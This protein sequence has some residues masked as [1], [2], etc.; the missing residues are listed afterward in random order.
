MAITRAVANA[1]ATSAQFN[2][3][4]DHLEGASGSTLAYFLRVLGSNNFTIRLPDAGGTQE[5]R[6]QDSGGTSVCTIDSDGNVT[7]A[8]TQATTGNTTLTANLT[9]GGTAAVT[10]NTSVAANL[11]VGGT[12]EL[13]SS[14]ITT[15]TA[16]G[17]LKH[18]AGGLEFDASAITTGGMLKGDS[19]GVMEIL[20]K[21]AANSLLTMNAGATDFA[22]A[23]TSVA[24]S[25]I[26]EDFKDNRALLCWSDFT[27]E[28]PAN[29]E[30]FD[31][32]V[33]FHY[34]GGEI[35]A[36]ASSNSGGQYQITTTATGNYWSSFDT[37]YNVVDYTKDPYF[38]ARLT[39]RAANSALQVQAWGFNANG[40]AVSWDDTTNDCAMFR[41][42]TTGNLFAVTGNG[43]AETT[44]D[45]GSVHTLGNQAVFEIVS[46][47]NGG[48]YVFK[49]NGTTRAT[50]TGTLPDASMRPILGIANNTTT[51]LILS[52]IDYMV[53]TQDRT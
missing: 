35:A 21:G 34:G 38:A 11:D 31:Y 47:S 7:F 30:S 1:T 32:G 50:H 15:S 13:G 3:I 52:G 19:S 41:S 53:A 42:I 16:A 39:S 36:D 46:S 2:E 29:N 33:T 4:I 49:I 9:V 10:G 6:I 28:I 51:A 18:E 43:S 8:G 25:A 17:L 27:M 45:L 5:F 44:T 20:A 23:A 37:Y 48:S 40:N 22:W 12:L 24:L 14:N 26:L